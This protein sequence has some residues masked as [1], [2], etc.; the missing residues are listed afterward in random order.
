[1]WN[2]KL[3]LGT[4]NYGIPAT[5]QIELFAKTGFEGF[6]TG[7][8]YGADLMKYRAVADEYKMMYQSVHAPFT[9]CAKLWSGGEEGDAAVKELC[10]CL[11][12]TS[13]A[14]VPLMISHAFI[15]FKDHTPTEVGI[16]NFGKVFDEAER[17]GV[18][19][20]LE[21]TEGEEYLAA[22]MNEFK[23][24]RAVGFCLDTGHEMCYNRGKDLLAEYGDRL[25]A[26]HIND[27]LG[28]RDFGGGI[29]FHDDLHLLPFDGVCDWADFGERLARTGFDGP[30]TFEL[31]RTSQVGRADNAKYEKLSAEEYVTAAYAAACRVAVLYLRAKARLAQ[32]QLYGNVTLQQ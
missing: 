15:G 12:A 26:T 13:E 6:F 28:I 20:A 27:N 23:D 30:L 14:E 16:E 17:L 18:K 29:T 4:G 8:K 31:K 25:V 22:L 1:M 24:H 19:V 3:C 7:W 9:N 21:N 5:E 2:V 10:D 11:R 32:N